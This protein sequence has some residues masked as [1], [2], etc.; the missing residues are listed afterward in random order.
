MRSMGAAG[1]GEGNASE[2]S[3]DMVSRGVA[4]QIRADKVLGGVDG[5]LHHTHRRRLAQSLEHFHRPVR[6][7]RAVYRDIVMS[8][9]QLHDHI[10]GESLRDSEVLMQIALRDQVL[11]A[12][13]HGCDP[14]GV[15]RGVVLLDR[16]LVEL[17]TAAR[18]CERATLWPRPHPASPPPP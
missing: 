15:G 5:A 3:S 16:E 1:Y 12:L 8:P 4:R 10:G 2:G 9:G 11:R 14:L 7:A 6:T 13:L 18:R 17:C